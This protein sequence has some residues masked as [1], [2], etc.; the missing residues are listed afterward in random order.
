[1]RERLRVR[2]EGVVLAEVDPRSTPGAKSRSAAESRLARQQ[3]RLR[4]L[5]E[6]LYAEH[7]RSLLVVLQGMDTSGKDGTVKHVFAAVNPQGTTVTGFKAPTEQEGRHRFL[8]RIRR[9]LPGPGQIGIF[10]RS[11]YE[12]V[13]VVKIHGLVEPEE[14]ERRYDEINRFERR[15]VEVGTTVLKLCLHISAEEQRRR[16]LA[17]LDDDTKRWKFNPADLDDRDRWAAFQA[18]YEIALRRCSTDEAP[19]YVVPAD[20]KWYRNVAVTEILVETLEDVDP[21]YP[22]PILDIPALRARLGG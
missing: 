6:R 2:P 3:G 1:M 14:I 11:H 19:W 18:A 15:L 16:L 10:N 17:R 5:Q 8:W 9:R 13:I 7:A 20:R 4:E 21:R 22:Q 12:D